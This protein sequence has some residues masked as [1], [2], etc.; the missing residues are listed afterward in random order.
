MLVILGEHQA[1]IRSK[2]LA[3]WLSGVMKSI[4]NNLLKYGPFTFYFLRIS[5]RGCWKSGIQVTWNKSISLAFGSSSLL[6]LSSNFFNLLQL[7]DYSISKQWPFVCDLWSLS[8]SAVT[9]LVMEVANPSNSA[10]AFFL[11]LID[12]LTDFKGMA[13]SVGLFN[14]G[15]LK[16]S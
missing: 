9:L 14:E 7:S 5:F 1:V 11:W 15:G 16:C 2:Q 4:N 12:W 13:T 10:Q 6:L 8:S 3:V